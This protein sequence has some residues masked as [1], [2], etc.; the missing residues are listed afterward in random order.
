MSSLLLCVDVAS[1]P[2]CGN[3]CPPLYADL[4]VP[5]VSASQYIF[6][7]VRKLFVE[8]YK[9]DLRF[10]VRLLYSWNE[11]LLLLAKEAHHL[12]EYSSHLRHEAEHIANQIQQLQE[13]MNNVA[14]QFDPEITS[15]VDFATW[16]ELP[17]LLSADKRTR[18]FVTYN[19]LRCLKEDFRMIGSYLAWFLCEFS[20][21]DEC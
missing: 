5:V 19:L 1:H 10:V 12:P 3:E 13:L 21:V 6:F 2:L 20:E 11:P 15:K 4:F 8:F 17:S 16:T 7:N 18:L 9:D 14:S